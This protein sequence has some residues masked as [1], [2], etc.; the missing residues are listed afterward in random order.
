VRRE[1]LFKNKEKRK[2]RQK[3]STSKIFSNFSVYIGTEEG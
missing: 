2:K 3:E 1:E